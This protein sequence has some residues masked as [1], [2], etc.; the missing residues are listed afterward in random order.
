[1][2]PKPIFSNRVTFSFFQLL[3]TAVLAL[4][5]F[6]FALSLFLMADTGQAQTSLGSS[7]A[8]FFIG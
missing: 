7:V 4:I 2:S 1:M 3:G 8:G 5:F 6:S